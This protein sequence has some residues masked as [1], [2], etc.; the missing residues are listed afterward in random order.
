MPVE[1]TLA[2]L[3]QPLRGSLANNSLLD[4]LCQ[5]PANVDHCFAVGSS[6][7]RRPAVD[8][9]DLVIIL[10][11]RPGIVFE[12]GPYSNHVNAASSAD[13]SAPMLALP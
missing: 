13:R 7:F 1:K 8:S 3:R 4:G 12:Y 6:V 5:C 11:R 10:N 9:N 2:D